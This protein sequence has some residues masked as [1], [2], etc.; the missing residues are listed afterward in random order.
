MQ[1]PGS[2]QLPQGMAAAYLL[3]ALHLPVRLQGGQPKACGG[4]VDGVNGHHMAEGMRKLQNG[5]SPDRPTKANQGHQ[6]REGSCSFGV[7]LRLFIL[8]A[9]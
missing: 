5:M 8:Q 3:Q 1:Q 9:L 7:R 4:S 2:Y 6:S